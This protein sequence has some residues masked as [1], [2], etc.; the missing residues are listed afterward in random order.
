MNVTVI[1]NLSDNPHP[2]NA[3]AGLYAETGALA[4]DTNVTNLL[5]GGAGPAENNFV[6]GDPFDGNDVLLSRIAGA[7]TSFNLSRGVSG[8]SNVQQIITDNNVD[9]VTA[10]GAGVI[11][12][13]NTVPALPP[14]S[15]KPARRLPPASCSSRRRISQRRR[16]K[17]ASG[18]SRP[19]SRR[20]GIRSTRRRL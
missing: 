15:T 10:A 5:V 2:V 12:F 7:G 18:R 11:T 20:Q 9:P 13:V 19:R 1:G 8:A 4:G 14:G 3:L 17:T 6:D 16:F